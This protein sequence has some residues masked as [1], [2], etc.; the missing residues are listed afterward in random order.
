MILHLVPTLKKKCGIAEFAKGLNPYLGMEM[1]DSA[2]VSPSVVL[3]E[4]EYAYDGECWQHI[5][6]LRPKTYIY[7]HSVNLTNPNNA[8][9]HRKINEYV[10]G[11][12]VTTEAM[13]NALKKVV[14]VPIHVVE[15]YSEPMIDEK[16]HSDKLTIG[17]HGFAV[18][19]TCLIRA[20]M[21]LKNSEELRL[22]I[23]ST[24]NDATV[25][26]LRIS[27]AYLDRCRSVCR[28]EGIDDRVEFDFTYYKTKDEIM[29]QL[30]IKSDIIL[31]AQ[32]H[33]G[34]TLNASGTARVAL[35][36]GRPVVVPR[37]PQFDGLPDGVVYH[38]KDN[39]RD[40][41]REVI[42]NPQRVID[43]IDMD[44]VKG[45]IDSTSPKKTAE[46]IKSIMGI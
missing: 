32:D 30:A 39:Y 36:S 35:S 19:R 26:H 9:T 2:I 15:H 8:I 5:E 3:L 27:R 24:I 21:E 43:S 42:E 18:P 38:M 11:V 1:N 23:A 20:I 46:K 41:I 7:M 16:R 29:R 17:M 33:G 12:F 40:S 34:D 14:N 13:K 25:H 31:L 44:K 28:R 6:V 10:S 22:F 37:Y 4:H 45:Y